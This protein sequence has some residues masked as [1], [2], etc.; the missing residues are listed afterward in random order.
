MASFDPSVTGI[1]LFGLAAGICPC[2]SVVCLGL[3]GYLTGGDTTMTPKEI[4]KL[5]ISFSI[6][7]VLVLL[8]L[9][10]IA[11]YVGNYILFLNDAAAWG[12]GGILMIL[13]GLQLLHVYKPPI[14]SI[15]NRFKMPK[16]F[17][18]WGVFL[19]GLS[20]GAITIG[21]GA[22]MLM[23]VLTYIALYQGGG[24]RTFHD[25]HISGGIKHTTYR[26]W[27]PWGF[28][29]KEDKGC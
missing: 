27:L 16:S 14:R 6:G 12:I 20:F 28:I 8:P 3:I 9:G 10:L 11:G 5:V 18:A 7:A 15:Y 2:N 4:V 21:R 25:A 23:I 19:I 24:R 26:D 22:P 13:M 1:F 29:R 17:T